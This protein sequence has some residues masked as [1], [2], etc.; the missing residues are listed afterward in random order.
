MNKLNVSNEQ[1]LH[2]KVVHIH[3]TSFKPFSILLSISIIK[4]S[5]IH[6]YKEDW[7]SI[8][9]K[10][11]WKPNEQLLGGLFVHST[12]N[13]CSSC[14]IIYKWVKCFLTFLQNFYFLERTWLWFFTNISLK[15]IIIKVPCLVTSRC[16]IIII[17]LLPMIYGYIMFAKD[18]WNLVLE[19]QFRFIQILFFI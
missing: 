17:C 15:K 1:I 6:I 16:I 10:K 7:K 14:Y 4:K 2:L 3:F 19:I 18:F 8:F 12:Y 9:F 5:I 11:Q 13:S